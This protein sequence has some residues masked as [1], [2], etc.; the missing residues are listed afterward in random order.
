MKQNG[1]YIGSVREAPPAAAAALAATAIAIEPGEEA[2]L[3]WFPDN[4]MVEEV[5][6][7]P[8]AAHVIVLAGKGAG[9]TVVWRL[10][11][12]GK[13]QMDVEVAD[14]ES[15]NIITLADH[16]GEAADVVQRGNVGEG[17]GIHWH[18]LTMGTVASHEIV[19]R[20]TGADAM[21]NV[22]WMFYVKD[23]EQCDLSV[24]NIF[25]APRGGGEVTM[26]GI[27]EERGNGRCRGL[28]DIGLGGGGTNTYL[29]QEVLMLDPTAK[30][31]AVPALEI[32]TNDVKASHSATVARVTPEDLFYLASRGIDER[33]ARAMFVR[34]FLGSLAE[35]IGDAAVREDV[36]R[37]IEEKYGRGTEKT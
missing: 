17:G 1:I 34:G 35:K 33:S 11:T 37:L 31:D 15:M 4:R 16:C 10:R 7:A 24:R 26:R 9:A 30:V 8:D 5:I 14:G 28:I 18:N 36:V 3:L 12:G 21:S 13:R 22:D 32:K 6:E 25:D 23:R 20:C 29:T 19:S 27:A 2:C